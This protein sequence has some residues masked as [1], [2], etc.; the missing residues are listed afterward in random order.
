MNYSYNYV[1]INAYLQTATLRICYT[2][3]HAYKH[4]LAHTNFMPTRTHAH[5]T[6][7]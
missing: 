2:H 3:T 7:L 4:T 1:S 6:H 5:T